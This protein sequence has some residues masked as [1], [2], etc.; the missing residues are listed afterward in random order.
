DYDDLKFGNAGNVLYFKGYYNFDHLPQFQQKDK[1]K[2][3]LYLYY[4]EGL[5]P[6]I[7]K[8]ADVV[9]GASKTFVDEIKKS[10]GVKGV[11]VPQFTNPERFTPTKDDNTKAY[12]VLFVGSNHTHKGRKVVDYAIKAGVDLALFGKFWEDS[13]ALP[14]LKGKYIDN[15]KLA[16][17]YANANIV[18]NDHRKDMQHYGFISNRIFDV[19]AAGGFILTDYMPEIEQVYGDSIATYKD[20][21]EFKSKLEFYLE[22]PEMRKQMAEKARQITLQNFTC[23]LAAKK[24][25]QIFKN[26]K[27]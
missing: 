8:E 11:F 21:D 14:Y 7:L 16:P 9:A 10:F 13:P 1:R 25:E 19:T 17:Y 6:N 3:V 4:I 12:S 23:L 5:N 15:D 27:K 26:I 22:H 18:L 24:I 20:F 2:R